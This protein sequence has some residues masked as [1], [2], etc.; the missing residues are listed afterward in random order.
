MGRPLGADDQEYL[1]AAF[2]M[3]DKVTTLSLEIPHRSN[4]T[5]LLRAHSQL[6][7]TKLDPSA[8][9]SRIAIS[10]SQQTKLAWTWFS[11]NEKIGVL[12]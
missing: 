3:F 10:Q 6:L 7:H 2:N 9:T 12:T 8:L 1:I 11:A 5:N 4:A